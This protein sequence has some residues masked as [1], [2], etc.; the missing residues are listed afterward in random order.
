MAL[1]KITKLSVG[2]VRI[3]HLIFIVGHAS[4]NVEKTGARPED[5]CGTGPREL[6]N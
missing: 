1:L 4:Y 2:C 6:V 3:S 5:N